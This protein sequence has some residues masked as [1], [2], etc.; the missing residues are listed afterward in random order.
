MNVRTHLACSVLAGVLTL[1]GCQPLNVERE[2][3]LEGGSGK[4][5]LLD[6]P[7]YDQNVK[8]EIKANKNISACIVP[9]AQDS[10]GEKA[11]FSLHRGKEPTG[12]LAYK[13]KADAFTLEAKIPAKTGY[14][15]VVF[16][17]D[18]VAEIKVKVTGR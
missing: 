4:Q 8:V 11:E 3:T 2:Y 1:G 10:D 17:P 6:P 18:G 16:N 12:A 15:V 5:L 7:K 14:A 9:L 13:E